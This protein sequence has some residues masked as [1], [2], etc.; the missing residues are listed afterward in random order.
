MTFKKNATLCVATLGFAAIV[1]LAGCPEP[2]I[3][4]DYIGNVLTVQVTVQNNTSVEKS[5]ALLPALGQRQNAVYQW[6]TEPIGKADERIPAGMN[7]ELEVQIGKYAYEGF[8]AGDVI[9][10]FLLQVDGKEY[11][12]WADKYGT[13]GLDGKTLSGQGYAVLCEDEDGTPGWHSS[14]SPAKTTDT[15]GTPWEVTMRYTVTVTGSNVDFVLEEA[16]L[17]KQP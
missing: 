10:S 14:L 9:L 17:D 16:L 8:E 4:V 13:A 7:K 3:V 5:V 6:T 2:E 15:G 11:A 1:L 12:G